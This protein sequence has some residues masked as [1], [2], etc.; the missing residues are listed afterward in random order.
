MIKMSNND[1][2]DILFRNER[3]TDQ[4]I[5]DAS[6]QGWDLTAIF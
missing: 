6:Q 3:H 5:N 4:L 2:F 1:S